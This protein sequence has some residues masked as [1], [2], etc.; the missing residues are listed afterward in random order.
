MNFFP[1]SAQPSEMIWWYG[2]ITIL[3]VM[4]A[5][6]FRSHPE[7]IKE[8]LEY[9]KAETDLLPALMKSLGETADFD[10]SL[11]ITLHQ[12]CEKMGWE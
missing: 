6:V 4:I 11:E 10:E 1:L 8:P 7:K 2:I 3:L 9:L 5:M 12:I